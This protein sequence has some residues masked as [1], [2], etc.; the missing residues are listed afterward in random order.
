ML[1]DEPE[2]QGD[3][4]SGMPSNQPNPTVEFATLMSDPGR[5]EKYVGMVCSWIRRY[6]LF[7][8]IDP[9]EVL[10]EL[11]IYVAEDR[12]SAKPPDESWDSYCIRKLAE[13]FR[14]EIRRVW[15]QSKWV[16]L[17]HQAASSDDGSS[18]P[19]LDCI[20]WEPTPDYLSACSGDRE[21]VPSAPCFAGPMIGPICEKALQLFQFLVDQ[22]R[23]RPGAD[24][25]LFK[26]VLIEWYN[27]SGS[28]KFN[29]VADWHIQRI[30]GMTD[31]DRESLRKKLHRWMKTVELA[32]S[33][34]G[35][36]ADLVDGGPK[37]E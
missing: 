35:S 10:S 21:V 16:F 23:I 4:F 25:L 11:T 30:H 29:A 14:T 12:L 31:T 26:V 17:D 15:R 20:Q 22:G 27:A 28:K 24:A 2:A 3:H 9:W 13:R 37:H 36:E 18:V 1:D 33:A 32:L 7:D 5:V 19:L 8:V 6:G 34:S